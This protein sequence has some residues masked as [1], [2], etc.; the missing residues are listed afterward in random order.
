[1][2]L[3]GVYGGVIFF[4]YSN[5]FAKLMSNGSPLASHFFVSWKLVNAR[6]TKCTGNVA[7]EFSKNNYVCIYMSGF[8]FQL[9]LGDHPLV[10]QL[11]S[12]AAK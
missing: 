12:L 1:M 5:F 9:F 8:D 11:H 6:E 10:L 4:S 7:H 2:Q 3:F